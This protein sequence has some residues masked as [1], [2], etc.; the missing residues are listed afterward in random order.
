MQFNQKSLIKKKIYSKF[1]SQNIQSWNKWKRKITYVIAPMVVVIDLE[2]N[3]C[4][5]VNLRKL[6]RYSVLMMF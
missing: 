3:Y 5:L 6:C 4:R 1:L 2:N